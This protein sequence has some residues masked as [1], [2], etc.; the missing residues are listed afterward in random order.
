MTSENVPQWCRSAIQA[1]STEKE[2]TSHGIAQLAIR[3]A[4]SGTVF[5]KQHGLTDVASTGGP[6]SLTTFL[7]PL[8]LVNSG[9]A[10]AKVGVPGRPAGVV[11]TF[12][13]I[14]GY[15]TDLSVNEFRRILGETRFVNALA[16][17]NFVPDDGVLFRARQLLGAQA[18]PPLVVASLL[19]KKYAVGLDSFTIDI[20]VLTGGNFGSTLAEV[21]ANARLLKDVSSLLGI[22][23]TTYISNLDSPRQPFIGRWEAL[24]ALLQVTSGTSGSWLNRHVEECL[25]I[26]NASQIGGIA[27]PHLDA[28]GIRR[29]LD[30]NLKAQGLQG[31]QSL[32]DHT[33]KIEEAHFFST[34]S[35]SHT[36]VIEW[37]L[38][39]LRNAIVSQQQATPVSGPNFPDPCGVELLVESGKEVAAGAPI[40][41]IRTSTP[42]ALGDFLMEVSAASKLDAGEIQEAV[43]PSKVRG[44]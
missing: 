32:M 19:A 27:P 25:I 8:I 15:Q 43:I 5:A 22:R 38:S 21:E 30:V 1:F 23:A 39:R 34:V 4:S 26:V 20:R 11:D 12:G 29:V 10:V 2:V 37:D 44:K 13:S 17:D 6:S 14:H 3:L 28:D 35:A 41:K 31:I 33:R 40:A 24:V 36:G 7:C 16:A 9:H 18:V 42:A